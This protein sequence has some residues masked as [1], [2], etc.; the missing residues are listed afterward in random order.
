MSQSTYYYEE[1]IR[2]GRILSEHELT[3]L[4][5]ETIIYPTEDNVI[6]DSAVPQPHHYCNGLVGKAGIGRLELWQL[7]ISLHPPTLFHEGSDLQLLKIE[8][9]LLVSIP[10]VAAVGYPCVAA[11]SG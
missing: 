11:A 10:E 8:S 1:P 5:V 9:T 2:L 7:I 3:A 6:Q 4:T